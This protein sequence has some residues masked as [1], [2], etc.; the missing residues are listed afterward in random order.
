MS[1]DLK[2]DAEKRMQKAVESLQ[3]EMGKIR[4]GRANASFLDHVQV[5]YYGSLTPL[6]Q[7]A[8]VTASDSRTL[9]VTPFEKSMVNAVE[10]SILNADLGLNPASMGNAIRVPMP[11][12]TEER[13]KE[14]IKIVRSEAEQG[15]V[16]IRN[17]RRDVNTQLKDLTKEKL[18]SEDEER[19][20]SDAIQKLTDQYSLAIDAVLTEKE[21]DL[22]C[23]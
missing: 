2:R 13:R 18:I 19:R 5:D 8:S 17:I 11:A 1:Q 12:L 15:R 4:T 9:L 16:S 21:K 20:A 6:K 14:M 7:V 23:N 22:M 10:K 3:H